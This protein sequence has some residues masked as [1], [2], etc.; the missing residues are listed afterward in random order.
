M[1]MEKEITVAQLRQCSLA[2]TLPANLSAFTVEI[3][4]ELLV[5]GLVRLAKTGNE[6][7]EQQL[8]AHLTVSDTVTR[9]RLLSALT[10]QLQASGC[11]FIRHEHLMYPSERSTKMVLRWLVTQLHRTAITESA[12]GK[13]W[14]KLSPVRQV[15]GSFQSFL[16]RCT[17]N[18]D[19]SDHDAWPRGSAPIATVWLP[20]CTVSVVGR[21]A[22]RI[23]AS[24]WWQI[25]C[26]YKT[27]QDFP[28]AP[29]ETAGQ[30]RWGEVLLNSFQEANAIERTR[31]KDFAHRC[32]TEALMS[33]GHMS[34]GGNVRRRPL[35]RPNRVLAAPAPQRKLKVSS[36]AVDSF[37]YNPSE[38]GGMQQSILE[39]LVNSE[40]TAAIED[41][42]TLQK[43][44]V[45]TEEGIGST[46]ALAAHD[47]D[48]ILQDYSEAKEGLRQ[49]K[50]RLADLA[51]QK[52]QCDM[53]LAT[54][55]ATYE[56][57]QAERRRQKEDAQRLE[58]V[59]ALM[60]TQEESEAQIR[61]EI[62]ELGT[63]R[64]RHRDKVQAKLQKVEKKREELVEE[65]RLVG[66]D[67]EE[68]L[69]QMRRAVKRLKRQI[70]E[71]QR[72]VQEWKAAASLRTECID[73]SHFLR[74]IYDMTSNLCKQQTQVAAV[75]RDTADCNDCIE[76]LE[77]RL[78]SSFARREHD[79]YRKAASS[80]GDSVFHQFHKSL[81]D[82]R[83]GYRGLIRAIAERGE[84]QLELNR[85]EERLAN[86]KAEVEACDT[87]KLE[88][89]LA[90][91]T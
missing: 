29:S 54:L 61:R 77:R 28:C 43:A 17:Q 79:V 5:A 18:S 57:Q 50:S 13:E 72:D 26:G 46:E 35:R 34:A 31:E 59:L 9:L 63:E 87:T 55:M 24:C 22:D 67:R 80:Q 51:A 19:Y 48:A 14:L 8:P 90:E 41:T 42:A 1:H 47:E 45:E 91:L 73:R 23:H 33:R 38:E 11:D 69:A 81:L 32:L 37:F 52:T 58:E 64:E 27:M 40:A 30:P 89:D 10:V 86:L 21:R 88:A 4:Y 71:K 76:E 6:G 74:Y 7:F 83:D 36:L 62:A 39:T 84:L 3:L 12:D 49:C 2:V 75:T 20:F 25:R 85:L 70:D 44:I 65:L 60:D 56:R 68:Q 82:M 78:K 66:G 15:L 53:D 16:H